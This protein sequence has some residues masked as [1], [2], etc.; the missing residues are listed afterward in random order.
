MNV[1]FFSYRNGKDL[2]Y[3]QKMHSDEGKVW[4]FWL[5]EDMDAPN[6]KIIILKVESERLCYRLWYLKWIK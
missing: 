5:F 3:M 6:I 1:Q 4:N 2:F